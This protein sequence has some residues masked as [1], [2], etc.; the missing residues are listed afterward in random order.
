MITAASSSDFWWVIHTRPRCEKKMDQWLATEGWAHF[1]PVQDR[2]RD[3]PGKSVVFQIP[4][5]PGYAFGAFPATERSRIYGSGFAAGLLEVVDQD[6]LVNQ[7]RVLREALERGDRAEAVP[8]L[9]PGRRVRITS[10]PFRGLE[11]KVER[12]AGADRIILSLDIL[13]KSVAIEVERDRLRLA[14]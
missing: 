13:E 14:A 7:L 3:Y 4:L 6:A 10:G 8:Y 12:K 11:G 9:T 1:L 5:F 2:R